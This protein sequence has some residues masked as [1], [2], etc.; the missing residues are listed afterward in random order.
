MFKV[1]KHTGLKFGFSAGVSNTTYFYLRDGFSCCCK[2][3]T[4]TASCAQL[5][6]GWLSRTCHGT[7]FRI[8]HSQSRIHP[9]HRASHKHRTRCYHAPLH[10]SIPPLHSEGS[11]SRPLHEIQLLAVFGT[12]KAK[13]MINQQ[14]NGILSGFLVRT[15]TTIDI[16]LSNMWS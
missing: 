2:R 10:R 14:E 12:N 1:N 4:C 7:T 9:I 16:N 11:H 13:W 15:H 6:Q 3:G 8:C 5:W